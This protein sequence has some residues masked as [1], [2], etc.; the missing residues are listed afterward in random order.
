[1]PFPE[2][3]IEIKGWAKWGPFLV[4]LGLMCAVFFGALLLA[5][6]AKAEHTVLTNLYCTEKPAL[7]RLV[8]AIS[9]SQ[10]TAYEAGLAIVRDADWPCYGSPGGLVKFDDS[11]IERWF[12]DFAGDLTCV[13]EGTIKG[14][15]AWAV[16][17]GAMCWGA[18]HQ[19][20]PSG[21]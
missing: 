18:I 21:A 11:S 16:S 10:S 2:D 8:T 15:P 4:A 7:E 20:T 12:D 14:S 9:T 6:R 17:D 1:M 5:P 19:E 3:H 13:L